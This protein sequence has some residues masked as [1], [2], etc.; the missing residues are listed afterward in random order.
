MNKINYYKLIRDKIPEIIKASGKE[1]KTRVL[2][3]KEYQFK[4]N[5]KLSEELKEYQTHHSIEELVDIVE[6]I[7]AILKTQDVSLE[8]FESMRQEKYQNRGGFDKRLLLE[9]V[10]SDKNHE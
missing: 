1:L 4:L 7:Y 6:V 2:L 8:K 9:A 3:N 10:W 5:E